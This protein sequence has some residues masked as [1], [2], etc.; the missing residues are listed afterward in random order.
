MVTQYHP[1]SQGMPTT[2]DELYDFLQIRLSKAKQGKKVGMDGIP[3]EV[4]TA[5][6]GPGQILVA[7]L[8][9]SSYLGG[10]THGLAGRANVGGP[11]QATATVVTAEF[12]STSLRR[13]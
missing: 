7:R 12:E 6:G 5:A 11:A 4:F 2:F 1:S 13:T 3:N 10:A 8:L 9:A